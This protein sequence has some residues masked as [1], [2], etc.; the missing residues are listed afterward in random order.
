[1]VG[2]TRMGGDCSAGSGDSRAGVS[3]ADDAEDEGELGERPERRRSIASTRRWRRSRQARARSGDARAAES[4]VG[5]GVLGVDER[6]DKGEST[7]TVGM[8]VMGCTC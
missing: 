5:E 2:M 3:G 4:G 8:A 6:G 7:W 1:M